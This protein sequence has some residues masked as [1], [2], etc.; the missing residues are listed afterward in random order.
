MP[1]AYIIFSPALN[2]FYIG[3]SS[4]NATQRLEKHNL[5][6]YGSHFTST[7]ND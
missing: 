6:S 5:A 4:E 1:C 2:K 7:A 3:A